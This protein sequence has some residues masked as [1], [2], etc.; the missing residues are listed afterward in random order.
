MMNINLFSKSVHIKWQEMPHYIRE[1]VTNINVFLCEKVWSIF[2]GRGLNLIL[3]IY[4][5]L[6]R[7]QL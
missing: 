2:Q 7:Q 5:Q 3:E 1:D 6:M 4:S